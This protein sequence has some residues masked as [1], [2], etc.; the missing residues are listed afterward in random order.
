VISR[1]GKKTM[2]TELR[3]RVAI[4]TL[5]QTTDNEGGFT[6]EWTTASEA[7]AAVLPIRAAQVFE[8]RSVNV[9]ATHVVKLRGEVAISEGQRIL[10]DDREF[11]VLTVEDFQERGIYKWVVCNEKR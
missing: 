11:D 9:D 8:F 2:A 10:F 7:W 1:E 3:H 4:Q 6:S 5:D